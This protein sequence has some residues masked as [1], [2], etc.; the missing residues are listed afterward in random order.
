M[1]YAIAILAAVLA[2]ALLGLAYRVLKAAHQPPRPWGSVPAGGHQ[3]S[4]T[5]RVV[6]AVVSRLLRL[7]VRLGVRVGPMMILTVRGRKSGLPRTNLVDLFERDG[8][9]WIVATHSAGAHWVR[10]L[11]A[12]GTGQLARG[13]H[14]LDFT[15]VELSAAEAGAVLR[16]VLG[17]RLA[18]PV[19][20][21]VLRQTLGVPATASPA[22]FVTVAA[23][24]PVFELSITRA[25]TVRP[26]LPPLL[27]ATGLLVALAHATLGLAGIMKPAQ[28]I[29]GIVI[30]LLISG[31]GNHLRIFR[32]A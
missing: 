14:H 11:R 2:T 31:L 4:R 17:P 22:E 29:S 5:Q 8:R 28:W 25:R 19:N 13:R 16:E 27:I 9:R 12:A 20:G 1:F 10:N 6:L 21:V 26:A 30:G 7:L 23:S 15:A 18:R 32:R 24:H 3:H